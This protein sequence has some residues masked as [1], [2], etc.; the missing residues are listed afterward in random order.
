[1]AYPGK[2]TVP[3]KHST[4]SKLVT[5]INVHPNYKAETPFDHR[6]IL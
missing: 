6:K 2:T 1:M 3:Y 5:D 4:Y